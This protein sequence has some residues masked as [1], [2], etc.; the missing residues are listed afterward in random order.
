MAAPA[1]D[2]LDLLLTTR[3]LPNF[4][5]PDLVTAQA[6][7]AATLAA[8]VPVLEYTNRHAAAPH[9]FAELARH[10]RVALPGLLL[11]AGTITTLSAAHQFL[12]AGASFIVGPSFHPGVAAACRDRG[13]LYVP[14]CATPTEVAAAIEH[15]AELI[16]IFPA[17]QLGGPGFI[18]ALRGPFPNAR[19]M[20]SGGVTTEPESLGRWLSAG[21]ACLSIG[22]E[23]F[24]K[25]TL[26]TGDWS[27]VSRSIAGVMSAIRRPPE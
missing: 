22:G 13:V 1:A 3:L 10:L 21:A 7:A 14:G 6:V 12:D 4:S 26:E 5:T 27:A 11:G 9:V 16:K 19:F 20:P 8:G 18:S 15:G 17:A 2:P 24:P 23:L 25:A